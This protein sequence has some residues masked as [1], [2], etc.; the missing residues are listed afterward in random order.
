MLL[1]GCGSGG[2]RTASR[3]TTSAA[4]AA[5][6]SGSAD[7]E[8][9]AACVAA[10]NN[11]SNGYRFP[12][13]LASNQGVSTALVALFA[14]GRCHVARSSIQ[15]SALVVLDSSRI[16]DGIDPLTPANLTLL[17]LVFNVAFLVLGLAAQPTEQLAVLN[18]EQRSTLVLLTQRVAAEQVH[19][20]LAQ[21]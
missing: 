8:E 5:T 20:K 10:W 6:S 18:S 19:E 14:D 1:S 15:K 13:T 2:A 7:R 3:K 12:V 21:T 16:V 17:R 9:L 4:A 11:P